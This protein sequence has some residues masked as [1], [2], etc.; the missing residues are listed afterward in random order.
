MTITFPISTILIIGLILYTIITH[1]SNWLI[2]I[3][4]K[5]DEID[6]LT[7]LIIFLNMIIIFITINLLTHIK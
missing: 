5:N 6:V 4:W 3:L 1:L 7:A 2:R